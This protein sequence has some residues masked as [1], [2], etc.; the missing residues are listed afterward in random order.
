M[1]QYINRPQV[2]QS[3]VGSGRVIQRL[4]G[5]EFQ[6]IKAANKKDVYEV[7]A[8]G[9]T[10]CGHGRELKGTAGTSGYKIAGD[11]GDFEYET[12]PV[13]ERKDAEIG[14]LM[15]MCRDAAAAHR[16]ILNTLNIAQLPAVTVGRKTGFRPVA[17]GGI[18]YLVRQSKCMEAHPQATAGIRLDKLD[19]F[20]TQFAGA[21]RRK[22]RETGFNPEQPTVLHELNLYHGGS[23]KGLGEAQ[24]DMMQNVTNLSR[25]NPA[26][27]N[28]DIFTSAEGKGLI[29]LLAVMAQSF[30]LYYAE[31]KKSPLDGKSALPLMPRTALYDMYRLLPAADQAVVRNLPATPQL[32]GYIAGESCA[33]K[34]VEG[35]REK[36]T[37]VSR[38]GMQPMDT[39]IA[40]DTTRVVSLSEWIAGLPAAVPPAAAP[41]HTDPLTRDAGGHISFSG[42]AQISRSHGGLFAGMTRSTDIGHDTPAAPGIPAAQVE[43][44]LMEI[45]NLQRN[46]DTGKWDLIARDAALLTRYVNTNTFAET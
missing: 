40:A 23:V 29:R 16:S 18:N 12:L 33:R 31:K 20:I 46:V 10:P 13:D 34:K 11:M 19:S 5:M 39:V 35:G 15:T 25:K 2:K 36:V 8:E 6:V 3:P 22:E 44:M 32:A 14:R 41:V 37:I 28:L 42:I 4:V 17:N 26:V 21:V 27:R 9:N 38:K 30:S 24:W 1:Y 43:G 7:T 45:R